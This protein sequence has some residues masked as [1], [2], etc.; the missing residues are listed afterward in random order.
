[1]HDGSSNS[2]KG[3][4]PLARGLR[5][6]LPRIHH[7]LRIIPAHGS[8]VYLRGAVELLPAHGS[9][10]LARGLPAE[11]IDGDARGGIIPARA[12]FTSQSS[13]GKR[14]GPDHPRSRGVYFDRP[15]LVREG[16]GSS[17]L[18]R[19][20]L[21]GRLGG[22]GPRRIIPARAGFTRRGRASRPCGPDH[23]R[24]RGVYSSSCAHAPSSFGSPPLARGLLDVVT[25]VGTVGRITPARAGFTDPTPWTA[26]G[27]TDHPRSRGVYESA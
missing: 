22:L 10:P 7:P 6:R 4:S 21:A 27:R 17:P 14:L 5:R 24:S 16:D 2:E 8:W 26:W 12:G 13:R 1:M 23:P 18:A 25:Q 9:S 15:D 19:G 11:G 3:S 20:L